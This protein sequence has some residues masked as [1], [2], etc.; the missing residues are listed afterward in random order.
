M[1]KPMLPK[2][3]NDVPKDDSWVYEVKYDGFRTQLVWNKEEIQLFSRNGKNLT[4]NVPEIISFLKDHEE[5]VRPYLPIRL[6]GELTILHTSIRANFSLLQQ[7]GRLK[8]NEKIRKHAEEHP[9]TFLCFDL[10][11]YKE[12]DLSSLA[13][14]KRK[15]KLK[16]LFAALQWP[17]KVIPRHPIGLITATKQFESLWNG[18]KVEYGEGVVAKRKNNKYETGK[19][20]DH[21]LK[22]KNWR[23]L[24]GFITEYD[25]ENEYFTVAIYNHKIVETLGVFKHGLSKDEFETLTTLIAEKG[26][27]TN[28]GIYKIPPGICVQVNC[29]GAEEGQLREPNF[30]QFRL[31]LSPEECTKEKVAVDLAMLPNKVEVTNPTKPLWPKPVFTKQDHLT[32]LRRISPFMLPHLYDKRLTIIRYP[33]GVEDESF[34]QKHRPDY[35]PDFVGTYVNSG[36]EFMICNTLEALIWIGNQGSIEFHIPFQQI[37]SKF[38]DEIVFDLDPPSRKEFSLAIKAARILKDIC[39]HMELYSFVKTSGNKGLQIHIPLP[40]KGLT[41]DQTREFTEAV[42]YLLVEHHPELFTIERLKKN[43]GNRLYVDYVQHAEGKTI[44]APYSP[45]ATDEGTVATPIYWEEVQDDLN[46]T[47]FTIKTVLDRIQSKGC[48]MINYEEI[49]SKQDFSKLKSLIKS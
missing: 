36:E 37:D 21:W 17:E 29:L 33:H 28:E 40:E 44:I 38:P 12:K 11:E 31:D 22:I 41:Y 19:R 5:A 13:L 18:L 35:A 27:K 30:D 47:D 6:D 7:R 2:L 1:W 23:K 10:L 25:P 45:R 48:P 3:S 42:A 39:N 24:T 9:A 43:R 26:E 4:Q 8:Q 14:N 32:Y 34:F 49:R 46:P 16:E 15:S 20:V